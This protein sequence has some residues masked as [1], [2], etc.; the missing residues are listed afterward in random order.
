ML[1][2]EIVVEVV[3][4]TERRALGDGGGYGGG[5]G[6]RCAEEYNGRSIISYRGG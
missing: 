6:D 2:E 4:M 1:A 3:V 5:Y